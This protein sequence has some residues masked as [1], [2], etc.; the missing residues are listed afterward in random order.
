MPHP[1]SLTHLL[2]YARGAVALARKASTNAPLEVR[3]AIEIADN[4]L[5]NALDDLLREAA[6]QA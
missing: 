2:S 1:S 3:D 4:Y 5:E 6:R